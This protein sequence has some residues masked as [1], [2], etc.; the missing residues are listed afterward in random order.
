MTSGVVWVAVG[1]AVAVT[2]SFFG[3]VTLSETITF[4]RFFPVESSTVFAVAFSFPIQ[5]TKN[6]YEIKY[7]KP[8]NQT[9]DY[10]T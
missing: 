9:I 1:V 2:L 7:F 5:I 6:N 4:A 8:L 10:R 3:V